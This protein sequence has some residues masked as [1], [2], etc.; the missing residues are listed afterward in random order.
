MVQNLIKL[1]LA[2]FNPFSATKTIKESAGSLFIVVL[3]FSFIISIPSIFSGIVQFSPVFANPANY[4]QDFPEFSIISAEVI[5][6]VECNSEWSTPDKELSIF[7]STCSDT[8]PTEIPDHTIYVTKNHLS[9]KKKSGEI[10]TFPAGILGD[11]EV[12]KK[13]ISSWIRIWSPLAFLIGLIFITIFNYAKYLI[14]IYFIYVL[15]LLFTKLFKIDS[16]SGKELQIAAFSTMIPAALINILSPFSEVIESISWYS[17][18]AYFLLYAF[19]IYKEK[20]S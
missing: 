16:L 20:H 17:F 15:F 4:L 14:S 7:F 10:R 3:A 19:V 5:T 8:I 13:N 11:W 1:S 12:T 6:E 9:M 18:Y 2:S